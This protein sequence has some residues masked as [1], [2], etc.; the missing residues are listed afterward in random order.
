MQ[1]VVYK[2]SMDPSASFSSKKMI[3]KKEATFKLLNHHKI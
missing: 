2:F 1:D 3:V